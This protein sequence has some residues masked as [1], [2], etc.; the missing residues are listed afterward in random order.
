MGLAVDIAVGFAVELAVDR[1]GMPWALPW[2]AMGF[3]IFREACRGLPGRPVGISV[4][5]AVGLAVAV[6]PWHAM[7]SHDKCRGL[8][9]HAVCTAAGHRGMPW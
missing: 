8:P 9:R 1:H 7:I 2:Q 6:V 3:V 5:L 4:A